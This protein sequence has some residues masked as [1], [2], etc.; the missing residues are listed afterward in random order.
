MLETSRLGKPKSSQNRRTRENE[1]TSSKRAVG[2]TR[3]PYKSVRPKEMSVVEK[4]RENKV[5]RNQAF[6]GGRMVKF[7]VLGVGVEGRRLKKWKWKSKVGSSGGKTTSSLA[8]TT[9]GL[10]KERQPW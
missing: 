8:E 4:K 9:G 3:V 2:E 5:P 10:E 1:F 6:E 7:R